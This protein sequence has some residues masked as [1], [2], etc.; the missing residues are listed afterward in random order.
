MPT[1][2][3]LC[4]HRRDQNLVCSV[5]AC[6]LYSCVHIVELLHKYKAHCARQEFTWAIKLLLRK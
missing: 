2:T 1:V 5:A 6:L 3:D 4:P